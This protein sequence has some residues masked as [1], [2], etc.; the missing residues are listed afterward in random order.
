VSGP[1][2]DSQVGD[3]RTRLPSHGMDSAGHDLLHGSWGASA[4]KMVP[5]IPTPC[6]SSERS[7]VRSTQR[8]DGFSASAEGDRSRD[9]MSHFGGGPQRRQS[10]IRRT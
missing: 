5:M 1:L 3:L 9:V 6:S 2:V 7:Q 8:L 4:A 10:S